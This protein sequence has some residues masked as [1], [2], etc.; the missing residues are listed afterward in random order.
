MSLDH[1]STCP[2][3]ACYIVGHVGAYSKSLILN[4][5]IQTNTR[6]QEQVQ[7][8]VEFICM[9][10]SLNAFSKLDMK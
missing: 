6:T 7:N 8:L 9:M 3:R 2:N 1:W 5:S 10:F 4:E